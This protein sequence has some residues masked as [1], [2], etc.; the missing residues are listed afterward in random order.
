MNDLHS[1]KEEMIWVDAPVNGRSLHYKSALN[2]N[3]TIN[4]VLI[5]ESLH[6]NDRAI[7]EEGRF[8]TL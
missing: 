1:L 3:P 4:K 8:I 7:P 2:S 6:Y 5:E